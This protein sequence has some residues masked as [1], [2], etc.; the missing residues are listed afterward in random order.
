[1]KNNKGIIV[2]WVLISLIGAEI[3]T[4][5]AAHQVQKQREKNNPDQIEWMKDDGNE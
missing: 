3:V 2:V 4:L 5:I 1:M